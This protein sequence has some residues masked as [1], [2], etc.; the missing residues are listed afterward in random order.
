MSSYFDE[1]SLVMIPSGYKDQ[2]VYSVK[3]LD[4]SGDLTFSRASSA[5][6]VASNGLIEKVRTNTILQSN[7]FSNASWTKGN[8]TVTS[9]QAG[10]DGTTN[11]WKIT[12]TGTSSVRLIQSVSTTGLINISTYLKAGNVNFAV[13]EIG[14][15]AAWFNLSNG[16][17][18]SS[19]GIVNF[20]IDAA[21]NGYYRCSISLTNSS[22]N[23]LSIYLTDADGSVSAAVNDFIYIQ[24]IQVE[25]GDIATDYIATT[26]AAVSVGPVSGL[27]RLDY[28]NSSCPRLLLE[29]QRTNLWINSEAAAT[30]YALDVTATS[31]TQTSPSGTQSA[32]TITSN[33]TNDFHGIGSD[34]IALTS[35]T[36]YTG[37]VFIKAGTGRYVQLL[38][39]G[40]AF[41]QNSYA[42]FD[43]QTGTITVQGSSAT[44]NIVNYG[45]G[46]YRCE[47]AAT[48]VNTQNDRF[49]VA[50]ITTA[51]AARA[52]SH[53]TALS[54]YVWG[55]Q[56]EAGAYA[57]SYIPT[58]GTSVT[59]VADA[60]SKTGIS[61][62]IGQTE[63]TIFVDFV[64]GAIP[65]AINIYNNERS[66]TTISTNAILIQPNGVIEAQTFR[67]NG[68]FDT[69][70]LV[71][72]GYSAG[73]R[74][75][76]GFRYKS[77]DFALYVNGVQKD[78][79]SGSL[80]FIGTKS[81]I[82]LDNNSEYYAFQ[83]AVK[84]NQ[85][86]QFKTPLT[87]AQLAE[88]TTL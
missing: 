19:G 76:V 70:T 30:W 82:E 35:G 85:L 62:L 5:T 24:N 64:V 32:D 14:S 60:A 45:N 54:Y 44:A 8:S 77:G 29:P 83:E 58:L 9:G 51:N 52:Q 1:A 61:S 6:R 31:N 55:A 22:T 16:T 56:T 71:A 87:N 43:L 47:V 59:R 42:N 81:T 86:L 11:G 75:K 18:G 72:T 78:T 20:K 53:T 80:T 74:L 57:T 50:V 73:Q 34:N 39:G 38:G 17:I 12:A 2:K 3:P 28:L 48:A 10:Y 79:D 65:R 68:T 84:Y 67:G 27:P 69:I 46:W 41:D 88:L 49:Y 40:G 21:G 4:G 33:T 37:S 15:A 25:T 26:S 66:A 7:T 13:F 63:G 23:N 36:K